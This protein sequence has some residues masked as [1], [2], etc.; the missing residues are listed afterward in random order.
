MLRWWLI[1]FYCVLLT[2][3]VGSRYRA[4]CQRLAVSC[5]RALDRCVE[6]IRALEACESRCGGSF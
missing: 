6:N 2:G 5:N 1:P 4:Q 3:C